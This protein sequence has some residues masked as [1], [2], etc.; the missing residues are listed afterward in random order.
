LKAARP[1]SF[2]P[3]AQKARNEDGKLVEWLTRAGKD[4]ID[5]LVWSKWKVLY[6]LGNLLKLV[7]CEEKVVNVCGAIFFG[8]WHSVAFCR[9]DNAEVG[10]I[11]SR[12]CLGNQTQQQVRRYLE[13]RSYLGD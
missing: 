3:F 7:R 4:E 9:D 5:A 12:C 11:E 6:S 1:V 8:G 13:S 10:T 2:V